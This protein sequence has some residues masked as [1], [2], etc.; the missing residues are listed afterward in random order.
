MESNGHIIT[1]SEMFDIFYYLNSRILS[2]T[3]SLSSDLLGRL[4]AAGHMT[5]L[6][7]SVE[8]WKLFVIFS[9]VLSVSLHFLV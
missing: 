8:K 3:F 9:F 2:I 1:Y 7:E 4:F 6:K 5:E